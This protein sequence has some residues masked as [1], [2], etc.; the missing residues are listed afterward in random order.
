MAEFKILVPFNFTPYEEKTLD[1]LIG[2]YANREAVQVTV[3][4][5]YTPLPAVDMDASP[6]MRKIAS[7]MAFLS[8]DIRR[9]EEALKSTKELLLKNGFMEDQIDYVFKERE[10]PIE[11]EI[12]EAA[13]KAHYRVVL[14]SHQPGKVTRFFSKSVHTKV[15]SAL[16]DITICIQT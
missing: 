14:L 10:K 4:H 12:I 8:E 1:F 9:K 6:E 15:L 11:E 16:K 2:T 13:S 3:F 7:G 5:A